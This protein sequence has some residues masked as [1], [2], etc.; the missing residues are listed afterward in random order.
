[1]QSWGN[2][3]KRVNQHVQKRDQNF[4]GQTRLLPNC[5]FS[6][7]VSEYAVFV[8]IVALAFFGCCVAAARACGTTGLFQPSRV[9]NLEIQHFGFLLLQSLGSTLGSEGFRGCCNH[10]I[11]WMCKTLQ[12]QMLKESEGYKIMSNHFTT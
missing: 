7:S 12:N 8:L 2:E 3:Q 9:T 4:N 10:S 11:T 1:M 6:V 5:Y